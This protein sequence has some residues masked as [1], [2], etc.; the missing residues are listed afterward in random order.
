MPAR[1]ERSQEILVT[2][3]LMAQSQELRSRSEDLIQS[4][5][6]VCQRAEALVPKVHNKRGPLSC[7]QRAL[8]FV[9]PRQK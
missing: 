7:K 1:S 3:L 6:R 4:S 2:H 9:L 8:L 5:I